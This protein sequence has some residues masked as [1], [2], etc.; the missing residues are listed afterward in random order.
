MVHDLALPPLDERLADAHADVVEH[1]VPRDALPA[2]AAARADAAQRIADSL[3]V[4]HLVQR[5]RA[6]G[7]VAPAA[8]RV[9]RVALELL[10]RERLAVD[11]GEE[12]AAR[13]A[14]EA[15]RRDQGVAPLDLLGPRDR[16]VLFP[17]VPALDGRIALEAA[18][19]GGELA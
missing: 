1:L 4:G 7:A 8:S 18:L 11:V 6:L 13:L 10:D 12:P 15:D 19:G 9:R 17:V 3:G 5:R 2:P 16:I 14:V